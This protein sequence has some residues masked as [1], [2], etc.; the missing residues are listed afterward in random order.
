MKIRSDWN[1]LVGATV[2][3]TLLIPAVLFVSSCGGESD[4]AALVPAAQE[5]PA[6]PVPVGCQGTGL[7]AVD[8]AGQCRATPQ[9]T[10]GSL[11]AVS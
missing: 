1:W 8:L 3:C 11:E 10:M 7:A 2:I 5:A 6:D 9:A 4:P